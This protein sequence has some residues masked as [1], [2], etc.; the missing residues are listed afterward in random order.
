LF[1][2]AAGLDPIE[3]VPI[4][5]ETGQDENSDALG[6]TDER[7]GYLMNVLPAD[8][9]I[10]GNEQD[11]GVFEKGAMLGFPLLRAASIAGGGDVPLR[12]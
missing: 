4:R 12:Q 6:D 3:N 7:T 9:V 10:I 11:V 8:V 1:A 2:R 5:R